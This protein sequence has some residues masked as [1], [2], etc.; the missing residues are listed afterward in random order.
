MNDKNRKFTRAKTRIQGYLRQAKSAKDI[1]IFSSGSP[2]N[3]LRMDKVRGIPDELLTF[4]KNL[5]EKLDT[6]VS[7][8]NK[9]ELATDFPFEIEVT[10]L[11]A[12]GIKF[13]TKETF[14]ENEYLEL[15]LVLNHLPLK[16]IG[17]ICQVIRQDQIDN[18]SE[19][20][21]QFTNIRNSDRE[22]IIQYVF[23]E[24]R[25][26]IRQKNTL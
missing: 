17:A 10:E 19:W 18:P 12:A 2:Q 9:Q 26:E 11:S 13:T 23:Y 24:Q 20:V 22:A 5:D 4:L 6:I 16:T 21:A 7:L 25:E 1:P 3:L 14:T 8:L 15:A